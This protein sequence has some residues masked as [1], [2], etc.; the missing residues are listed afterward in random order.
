MGDRTA[1]DEAARL[2]PSDLVDT[3]A[4]IGVQ[5]LIDGD[6]KAAGIGKQRRDIAELDA[7][8][9]EIRNRADIAG[10]IAVRHARVGHGPVPFVAAAP[11]VA[12]AGGGSKPG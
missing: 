3:C 8:F 6:A 9:G 7:R 2:Q 4:R 10:D 11:T 1:K 12:T 5:Q